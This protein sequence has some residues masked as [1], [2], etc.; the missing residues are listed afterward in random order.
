MREEYARTHSGYLPA[1]HANDAFFAIVS[2][3]FW[4]CVV[5]HGVVGTLAASATAAIMVRGRKCAPSVCQHLNLQ[6][7]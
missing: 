6:S 4:L 3:W 7:P 1:V 2:L 5:W